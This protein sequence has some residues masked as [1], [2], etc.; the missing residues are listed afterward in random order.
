MP[1][2]TA[3]INP[4]PAP[5]PVE[6]RR[7]PFAYA[8]RQGVLVHQW[9]NGRVKVWCRPDVDSNALAEVRRYLGAP[10]VLQP[11]ELD[12]F[13]YLLRQAYE[14]GSTE[15]MEIM[16]DMGDDV[17]LSRIAQ[18]LPEPED[19]VESQDDSPIIRLLNAVLTQAVKENASDIHSEP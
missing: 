9:E 3:Q 8:K 16:E 7:L 13:D 19:L 2:E 11:L 6:E 14:Q 18:Q 5:T 17:D 10:L 15:A 4:V 1:N 12:K